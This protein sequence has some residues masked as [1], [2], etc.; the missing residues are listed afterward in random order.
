MADIDKRLRYFNGQFLEQKDFRDEQD[1]HIDRQ[2]RHNRTLHTPGVAEGLEITGVVGAGE[3]TV[4]AGTAL[5]DE[6][7]QIVLT[8]KRTLNLNEVAGTTALVVIAYGEIPVEPATVGNQGEMTRVEERPNVIVVAE[9]SAPPAGSHIR[10][11]RLT[12]G[13]GGTLSAIVDETVRQSAGVRLGEQVTIPSLRLSNNSLPEQDWP[14]LAAAKQEIVTSGKLKVRNDLTVEGTISGRLAGGIVGSGELAPNA[15]TTAAIADSAVTANK[16]ADGSINGNK[17]QNNAVTTGR[18][19]D[20]SVTTVKI[21]DAGI[22]TAKLAD[23]GVTSAKLADNAVT[24]AKIL[25]GTVGA[26]EL[27]N[28]A[29][30]TAK[31]ADLSVT[32]AKIADLSVIGT[33]IP[34]ASINEVKFDGA[35]RAKLGN[36]LASGGTIGGN[37]TVGGFVYVQGGLFATG[38]L[39]QSTQTSLLFGPSDADGAVR[40]I[41]TGFRP[42]LALVQGSVSFRFDA[43]ASDN[44]RF[45]GVTS[46]VAVFNGLI[47]RSQSCMGPTVQHFS[48]GGFANYAT[49]F[50]G[51]AGA[52]FQNSFVSPLGTTQLLV[53]VSQVTATGLTFR[54]TRTL[55]SGAV[56]TNLIPEFRISVTVLGSFDVPVDANGN[57]IL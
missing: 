4:S 46:G 8:D 16:I 1:Y 50:S 53:T 20:A 56:A 38:L 18:I 49:E 25:D 51:V 17:L 15:V 27:A 24:A 14:S 44:N 28:N 22:T 33:K 7:Q 6:G 48:T 3:V 2:R 9:G 43:A 10:L 11:G 19:A 21:V 36:S 5:D 29:V 41:T 30:I 47:I 31:L 54:L 55:V 39:D 26:A 45:G 32:T 34:D 42:R 40:S 12:V 37:L 35:T 23:L 57:P 13:A 52:F